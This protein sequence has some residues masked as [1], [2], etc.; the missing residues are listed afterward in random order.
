MKRVIFYKK[1]FNG[2]MWEALLQHFYYCTQKADRWDEIDE[3]H[4][5]MEVT[6]FCDEDGIEIKTGENK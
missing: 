3:I 4:C 6:K 5:N 1:D 2:E